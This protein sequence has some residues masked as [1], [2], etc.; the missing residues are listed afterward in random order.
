MQ[1]DHESGSTTTPPTRTALTRSTVVC[2]SAAGPDERGAPRSRSPSAGDGVDGSVR[3]GL[4]A[5]KSE[6]RISSGRVTTS[7]RAPARD[8]RGGGRHRPG[9]VAARFGT[10]TP[11]ATCR[12]P[13]PGSWFTGVGAGAGHTSVLEL[14]NPDSAPPSRTSSSTAATA[15]GR[16][17]LR[18]VSVPG[19]TSVQVD[20]AADLPRRDELSLDVVAARGRIG[21][22]RP[23][24]ASTRSAAA[25]DPAGLAAG[26]VRGRRRRT[27]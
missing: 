24:T 25:H 23:W 6:A 18:G 4:G 12:A 2:P 27:C 14:T 13:Q 8:R 19:G 22:D 9:L 11:A 26:T 10:T 5:D 20:L 16:P 1:P 17:R 3:V 7:T 21:A 15:R